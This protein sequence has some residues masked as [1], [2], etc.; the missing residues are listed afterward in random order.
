MFCHNC[1]LKLPDGVNFC[2]SCGTKC[3]TIEDSSNSLV[4]I[5][6]IQPQ[7]DIGVTFNILGHDIKFSPN[8]ELYNEIRIPFADY[9][10]EVL[11]EAGKWA[12]SAMRTIDDIFQTGMPL[13]VNLIHKALELGVRL[14]MSRGVDDISISRLSDVCGDRIDPNSFIQY[15]VQKGSE[16]EQYAEE[17]AIKRNIA[18]SNRSRW[19]GGGFG[20]KGALKGAITA[21][22]LNMGAGTIHGI[23]DF[24]TDAGDRSTITKMKK[25]AVETTEAHHVYVKGVYNCCIGVF[26]GVYEVL[27]DRKILSSVFFD[28]GK[29]KAKMENFYTIEQKQL[30][31]EKQNERIAPILLEG[32]ETDPY[33]ILPYVDLYLRFQ[34]CRNQVLKV[35]EHFHVDYFLCSRIEQHLRRTLEKL[36]P[37]SEDTCQSI[38]KKQ[39]LLLRIENDYPGIDLDV[40]DVKYALAEQYEIKHAENEVLD[41]KSK[42]DQAI[43]EGKESYVWELANKG[44]TY[45]VYALET[46]YQ[47]CCGDLIEQHNSTVIRGR[48]ARVEVY[49]AGGSIAAEYIFYYIM[50]KAGRCSAARNICALA[51][52]GFP[53]AMAMKGFWATHEQDYCGKASIPEGVRLL[54]LAAEKEDPTA[55]AWLGIFYRAGKCGLPQDLKKAELLL[56]KAAA[57]GH[58]A[59]IKE[60]GKMRGKN[61]SSGCFITTAVCEHFGKGDE[62]YELNA[63]RS[64]R[65]NWLL[66][67][68]DGPQLIQQYYQVAP[69]IVQKINLNPKRHLIYRQIWTNFLEPCL[70]YIE[71]SDFISCKE[72]YIEMVNYYSN[73]A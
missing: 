42:I 13:T 15:F 3:M 10:V 41:L 34:N 44:N 30:S 25:T 36:K 27:L 1:G 31:I 12:N 48:I 14:L 32:I 66:L 61:E 24:I 53:A 5:H 6:Q 62:C 73:F 2:P 22:A 71:Q 23:G 35:A 54:E 38:K 68:P 28:T 52:K 63:F 16:I 59:A 9:G 65:D 45:A 20:V 33:Y 51:D 72:R 18:R 69:M 29:I 4:T 60:L 37:Q 21:G 8:T 11:Q 46:Y 58:P 67:Q 50:F 57:Y 43:S 56:T 49:A 19:C 70:K 26:D 39:E 64:F 40:H 17:L 7:E 47:T 55:L